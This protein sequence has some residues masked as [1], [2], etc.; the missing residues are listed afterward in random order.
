MI[1]VL[2]ALTLLGAALWRNNGRYYGRHRTGPRT[3]VARDH[4]IPPGWLHRCADHVKD[5]TRSPLED[6]FAT[7][8]IPAV[9]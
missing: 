7:V 3:R 2:A 8:P 1:P 4:M 6:L 5:D 9:T